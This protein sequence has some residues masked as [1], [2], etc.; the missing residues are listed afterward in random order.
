MEL[1]QPYASQSQLLVLR[2]LAVALSACIY[3][4]LCDSDTFKTNFQDLPDNLVSH[5]VG[6]RRRLSTDESPAISTAPNKWPGVTSLRALLAREKD[7]DTPRLVIVL[8][9]AFAAIYIALLL[10]GLCSYDCVILYHVTAHQ[11]SQETWGRLFGGGIKKLIRTASVT[12]SGNTPQTPPA[13]DPSLTSSP[14]MWL[15]KQR[16][17]L[18]CK[19]L[20]HQPSQIRE[21]K[22]TYREQFIPPE[23]SMLVYLLSKVS[24]IVADDEFADGYSLVCI[25]VYDFFLFGAVHG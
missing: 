1:Q 3:Q 4:S 20:G 23:M 8:C 22:P 12:N 10:Y 18:N 17:K 7:D 6:R 19:L 15:N 16:V 21:D 11:F 25:F 9:E 14:G 13:E 5:L 2:D 24:H